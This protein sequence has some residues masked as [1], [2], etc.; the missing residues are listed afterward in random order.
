MLFFV[1]IAA[2]VAVLFIVKA[3][4]QLRPG[5]F[6]AA[7]VWLG[8]AVYEYLM[9]NGVLCDGTCNIRVDLIVVWPLVW[10]ATLFGIYGPGQWTPLG[11]VLGGLSA[12]LL[13]AMTAVSLYMGLIEGPAAERARAAKCA[14]EGPSSPHCP[15]PADPARGNAATAR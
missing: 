13:V 6:V 11:K 14:A 5:V 12:F 9:T 15:P 4:K 2:A 7:A 10:L 1:A 3:S 8:Y